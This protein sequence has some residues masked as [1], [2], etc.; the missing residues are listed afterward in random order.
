[1]STQP[2]EAGVEDR[3]LTSGDGSEVQSGDPLA[4]WVFV[5]MPVILIGL[6]V[7]SWCS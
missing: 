6:L 5:S 7:W 4:L 3:P 2:T 1:M